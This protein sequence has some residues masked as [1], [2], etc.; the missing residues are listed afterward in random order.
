MSYLQ[1]PRLAFSGQFQSDVSTVNNDPRHYD[2]A[3][4]EPRFQEY[5]Q[6]GTT[7]APK[8]TTAGGTPPAPPSCASPTAR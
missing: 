7:G 6:A 1:F 5:Q 8:P 2:N 4:F 3:T